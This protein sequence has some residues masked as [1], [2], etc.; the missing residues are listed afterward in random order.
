M[1]FA[2]VFL[3]LY[4]LPSTFVIY[5]VNGMIVGGLGGCC[6][7]IRPR[8]VGTRC[9]KDMSPADLN[10]MMPVPLLT[11]SPFECE[12]KQTRPPCLKKEGKNQFK[13]ESGQKKIHQNKSI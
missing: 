13:I 4:V 10:D 6:G 3:H 12:V 7:T 11:S 9:G 5:L 8:R 1:V 2:S